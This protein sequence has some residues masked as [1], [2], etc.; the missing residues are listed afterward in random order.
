MIEIYEGILQFSEGMA[1][2]EYFETMK[3]TLKVT[4]CTA[5]AQFML[6]SPAD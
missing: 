2:S 5:G 6:K 4:L 3:Y 1:R